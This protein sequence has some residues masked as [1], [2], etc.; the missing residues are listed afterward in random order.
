MRAQEGDTIDLICWRHYGNCAQVEWVLAVNPLL[1]IS[2]TLSA[3]DVVFL[4]AP[5]PVSPRP[6]IS[7]WD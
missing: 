6:Q 4:P 3:G 5:S 2:A 1:C 7:L